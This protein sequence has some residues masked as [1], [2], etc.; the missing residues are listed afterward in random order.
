[1]PNLTIPHLTPDIVVPLEAVFLTRNAGNMR[2]KP[3]NFFPRHALH[4]TQVSHPR[5]GELI[6]APSAFIPA[7]ESIGEFPGGS[8]RIQALDDRY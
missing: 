4:Q 8:T 1:M 6:K 3:V 2:V 7:R 5:K